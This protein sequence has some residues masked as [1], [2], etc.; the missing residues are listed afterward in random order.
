MKIRCAGNSISRAKRETRPLPKRSSIV[1]RSRVGQV[2]L[3]DTAIR[4]LKRIPKA[5]RSFIKD[6]IRTHLADGDPLETSRNKF[7]LRRVSE[8]AEVE[9]RLDA[10]RVFY[11]V[12]EGIVEIVLIGAKRGNRLLIEGEE[13]VI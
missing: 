12:R 9:L 2:V 3:S 5:K 1:L 8:L 7:S 11:R 13:F 4:Q 6:G 10:W